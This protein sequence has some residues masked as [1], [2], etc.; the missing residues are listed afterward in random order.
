MQG[1]VV[2]LVLQC[3]CILLNQLS[4]SLLLAYLLCLYA[5]V[6][7]SHLEG[8]SVFENYKGCRS[9]VAFFILSVFGVIF[10]VEPHF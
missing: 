10:W 4:L 9:F 6:I 3:V 1:R 5:G 2:V 7:P 8:K